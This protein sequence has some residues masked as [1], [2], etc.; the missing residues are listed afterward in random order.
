M[1]KPTSIPIR[2]NTRLPPLTQRVRSFPSSFLAG[3]S[4]KRARDHST[5][6][7][8]RPLAFPEADP[9]D[10]VSVSVNGGDVPLNDF[11]AAMVSRTVRG[12]VSSLKGVKST[13]K[14]RIGIQ[15]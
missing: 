13:E 14:I 8:D 10:H 2:A 3:L 11:V 4:G 9:G 12:T 6:E 15:H 1:I 7:A 5:C